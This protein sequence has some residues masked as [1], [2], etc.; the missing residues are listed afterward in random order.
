MASTSVDGLASGIKYNE[1]I[2]AMINADRASTAVM[3]KRK[4]TFQARLEA[5]RGLNTR[6]LSHQLD[7]AS[8]SR[9]TLYTGRTA[10]TSNAAALTATATGQASTGVYQF[11]VL[12]VAKASQV[13]TAAQASASTNLGAGT[14]DLRLGAGAITTVAIDAGSSSLTS[15]AQA[16]NA[17][18][19]GINASVINDSGGAR[20]LLASRDTGTASAITV[21]AGGALTA[22]FS[23]L[24]TV[25][26]AAD[27]QVRIGSG[28]GAITLT[29][30]NNTF[31]DVVQGVTLTAVAA[32]SSTITVGADTQ[33]V[34]SAV[35]TFI[36]SYNGIVQYMK[37]NAAYDPATN[38][39]GVLFSEGD[40]RTRFNAVTQSLLQAVPGRPLDAATL[41]SIGVTIDRQSGKLS[42]DESVLD[43]KLAA[44]P[45]GVSRIFA[46]GG[47][48]SDP[49][50]QFALISDK[51]KVTAPF[52]VVITQA[53]SQAKVSGT[54]DLDASTV[55]GPANRDMTL[56]VNGRDY[57]VTLAAGSYTTQQLAAHVQSV[58]DQAIT[59][60][61]D[62][63]KISLE[64]DRLAITG[65]GYGLTS[66][67]QVAGSANSALR[68]GT[69]KRFGQDVEGT[70]NGV[71]ASGAGQT[72]TGATGTTAEGLR[73]TVTATA[74]IAA[75]TMTVTKGLA[76]SASE[77]VK[78]M[79]DGTFGLLAQKQTTLQ[80]TVDTIDKSIA[81]ADIR[82]QQR[83]ARYTAQFQAMEK[84]IN[85]SNSLSSF[86]AGQVKGFEN[87]ASAA[88]K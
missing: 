57:Q 75:A 86:F 5:V 39:A 33:G 70:I 45:S 88:S 11:E 51:T 25:Q 54:A 48:S 47:T 55:I 68:L 32:G 38:K 19:I 29:Q 87:A 64:G 20:L 79:T 31:K 10:S 8:L 27:A 71:A 9:P 28:G 65:S 16:I 23:G 2:D 36:E 62:K 58:F 66:S 81:A 60:A 52:A 46:N 76:Q 43:A 72:L 17:K 24:S 67:L 77:K 3:E 12:S 69:A 35:K 14:I 80:K 78:A 15:I 73:M 84:S 41:T 42:L 26:A 85:Q 22:A 50:I 59:V 63:V 53:A 56:T 4:D 61:A 30:S 6:L 44:D 74:P 37:D 40:V 83:R 18:N 49:G 7:L 34:K 1:I 82:L 21:S 13:A